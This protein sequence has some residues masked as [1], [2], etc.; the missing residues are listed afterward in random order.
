MVDEPHRG[1]VMEAAL[2]SSTEQNGVPGW[3]LDVA[4]A[5]DAKLRQGDLHSGHVPIIRKFH[6]D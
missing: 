5:P 4:V 2:V 1:M 3:L 6:P